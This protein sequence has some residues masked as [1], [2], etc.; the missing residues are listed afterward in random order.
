MVVYG[1]HVTVS[2]DTFKNT[3]H[4]HTVI[5]RDANQFPRFYSSISTLLY[6]DLGGRAIHCIEEALLDGMTAVRYFRLWHTSIVRFP[7]P[8][9][10]NRTYEN[11]TVNGY[12][13]SLINF[14]I[15][16][17]NLKELPSFSNVPQLERL[18]LHYNKLTTF[19]DADMSK[20]NSIY[21]WQIW[22]DSLTIFP[23]LTFLGAN[24]SLTIFQL[25]EN[26]IATV[27]CF[28]GGFTMHNLTH[29]DLQNNRIDYI[30][31]LNFAPNINALYLTGNLLVGMV[32]MESITVTLL[33]LHSFS[34]RFSDID[35]VSDSALNVIQNCRVLQMDQ[36]KIRVSE[37]QYSRQQCCAC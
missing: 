32:F 29:I 8:G 1:A 3:P 13:Q 20:L 4:L 19:H 11:G 35:H 34:M 10:S 23:N 28:P 14:T 15:D 17:S 18:I 37:Y 36:S 9:C 25:T 16:N 7:H 31:N 26:G 2:N 5:M 24:S 30:C 22:R 27:P 12:F 21:Q 6:V 33:S